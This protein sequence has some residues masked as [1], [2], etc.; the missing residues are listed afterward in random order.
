M[1]CASWLILTFVFVIKVNQRAY[2]TSMAL[3]IMSKLND[4]DSNIASQN[5][6]DTNF[7]YKTL[8]VCSLISFTS[9]GCYYYL[10]IF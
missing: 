8:Q 6:I 10:A 2:E 3:K 5:V 9:P 1:L 7:D 4:E